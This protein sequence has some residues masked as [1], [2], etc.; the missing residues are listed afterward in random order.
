MNNEEKKE[1]KDRKEYTPDNYAWLRAR[2]P[3]QLLIRINILNARR[4]PETYSDTITEVVEKGLNVV[5]RDSFE[6]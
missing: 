3:E 5:E 2:I 4:Y 1:V 6:G